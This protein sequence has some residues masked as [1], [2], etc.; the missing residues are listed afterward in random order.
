[1]NLIMNASH[2]KL[3]KTIQANIIN[4]YISF[5]TSKIIQRVNTKSLKKTQLKI[6]I[7]QMER[8][9]PIFFRG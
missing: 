4:Y 5:K 8:K 7:T 3:S 9:K 1:M 2:H 6:I